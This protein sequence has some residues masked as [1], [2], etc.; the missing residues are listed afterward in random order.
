MADPR[1]LGSTSL[2]LEKCHVSAN[3]ET[4]PCFS[5]GEK[6]DCA[7]S[8]KG[9]ERDLDLGWARWEGAALILVKS[10]IPRTF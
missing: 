7:F 4:H 8:A 6:M 3:T 10:S 9:G 2:M 1:I 5:T